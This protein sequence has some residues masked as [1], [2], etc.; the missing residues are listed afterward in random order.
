MKNNNPINGCGPTQSTEAR[1]LSLDF[2]G[3]FMCRLATDPD[4][5]DDPYGT[6]GYTM[7][8][9]KEPML[10]QVI[11]I[12]DQ[13]ELTALRDSGLPPFKIGVSVQS[14]SF[15]GAPASEA[16]QQALVGAQLDLLNA[17]GYVNGPT[18]VSRNNT[19]GSDDTM[20]F[21]VE[22]FIMTMD[23]AESGFSMRAQ[24]DLIPG[25]PDCY[26]VDVDQPSVY[27]RRLPQFFQGDATAHQAIGVYDEFGYFRDRRQWLNQRIAELEAL[28]A[29]GTC[30]DKAAI[31]TQ[32]EGLRTRLFQIETWGDRVINKLGFR[33]QWDHLINGPQQFALPDMD[34][35]GDSATLGGR[36]HLDQ[37][38]RVS[39]WFGS[40]DGDLLT[41]YMGGS[42]SLPFTPFEGHAK[43]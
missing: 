29:H 23:K 32:I 17:D 8:L 27:A 20:A 39:Y 36:V 30:V 25:K 21:V 37:P 22:P 28:I 31:E 11:R 42:L 9:P 16:I 19:V 6:S 1:Y 38:W 41:G 24:D 7:A 5:T 40:W 34:E 3:F 43:P 2:G 15:N 26:S 18:F 4:P 35:H 14:V 10:D 33:C 13:G 12:K